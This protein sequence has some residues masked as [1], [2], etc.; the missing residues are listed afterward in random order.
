MNLF[1]TTLSV[2][3]TCTLFSYP[4]SSLA[5]TP[6]N[7]PS[8]KLLSRTIVPNAGVV[9]KA[10]A[11]NSTGLTA[12]PNH[13]LIQFYQLPGENERAEL[14]AAGIKLLDY[15]PDNA[16]FAAVDTEIDLNRP[17]FDLIR[18]AGPILP[19]DKISPALSSGRVADWS[20]ES[21][22]SV[23]LSILF[24]NDVEKEEINTLLARYQA[25]YL[26]DDGRTGYV[27]RFS[28]NS[29][30]ADLARE[31]IVQW[32]DNGPSPVIPRD[33]STQNRLLKS[34]PKNDVARD[35]TRVN[36]LQTA[37][38]TANGTGV[39]LGVFDGGVDPAHPDFTGRLTV[40]PNHSSPA[41][42]HGTHVAGTMA[43]DGRNS[44]ANNGTANQW[45]GVATA[46][47]IFSY[48]N[49]TNNA[50]Q[51]YFQ[52]HQGAI[53]TDTIDISSNS[54][55]GNFTSQNCNTHN[56]YSTDSRNMDL[57]VTGEAYN[58]GIVVSVAAS[59]FRDG[60]S[61]NPNDP[62]PNPICN[63]NGAPDFINYTSL[64]DLGSAKNILSVGATQKNATDQMGDFSSW[65]PTRD[66]RL[67]PDI[68]APGVEITSTAPGGGYVSLSGTSMATPH[69]SG[70][71]ALVIQR[72][73][74]VFNTQTLQ[75]ATVRAILIQTAR[76]LQANHVYYTPGPD[77]ASGYGIAD[78]EAA[79]NAIVSNRVL[80]R[81]IANGATDQL[82]I[83]VAA[84]QAEFKV[85]L[86]WD[87]PAAALNV[88]TQLVNNL[89]LE[90]VAPNGDIQRP[91]VLDPNNPANA[92]TRGVDNLN[93]EEQVQ[94]Q[95]PAVGS[96]QLRMRG[97]SVP[98]GPQR[99][100][101]VSN[102]DIS[103]SS[104]NIFIDGFE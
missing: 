3:A 31:D 34:V 70:I 32:I 25:D 64:S 40:H 24:F 95:N 19:Q 16:W 96:W 27:A 4:L 17:P 55:G 29:V 76:D 61:D 84:N 71:A 22:G 89:D 57:I 33:I 41:E 49:N 13:V 18:W 72:Y 88:A 101:L 56:I 14:A 60:T 91:W 35:I 20:L 99:F 7:T 46:A 86:A 66:G 100:S 10:Q 78:A 1:K 11:V 85:T 75:P 77:F 59:N 36:A 63:F 103:I 104:D 68:V 87:D 15:V 73:R 26:S 94:V 97:T 37:V 53:V 51:N 79:Y 12:P 58:R 28:G 44:A 74:T 43:G 82:T 6:E 62:V 30:I 2:I 9:E 83:N 54:W 8:I 50:Q 80:E 69:I 48:D 93:N 39:R 45:R 67:K 102:T 5:Q 23:K 38:P 98:T 81:T 92:A 90:L 42:Q 21:D 52:S 47:Q 65:G